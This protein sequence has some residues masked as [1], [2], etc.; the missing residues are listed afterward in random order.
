VDLVSNKDKTALPCIIN[1]C[2]ECKLIRLVCNILKHNR[3]E[4]FRQ[5]DKPAILH[6]RW[7]GHELSKSA[8]K[9]VIQ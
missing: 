4:S 6:C 7:C 8:F 1:G 3:D 9:R 5:L 2:Q